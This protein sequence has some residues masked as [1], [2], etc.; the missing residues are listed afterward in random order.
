MVESAEASS[1]A[2]VESDVIGGTSLSSV[3]VSIENGESKKKKT[4]RHKRIFMM[5]SLYM[6]SPFNATTRTRTFRFGSEDIR[7]VEE[8]RAART[9]NNFSRDNYK[10]RNLHM[11]VWLAALLFGYIEAKAV[12]AVASIPSEKCVAGLPPRALEDIQ[13]MVILGMIQSW[14]AGLMVKQRYDSL[15]AKKGRIYYAILYISFIPLWSLFEHSVPAFRDIYFTAESR[16]LSDDDKPSVIAASLCVAALVL[17]CIIWHVHHAWANFRKRDAFTYCG[18]RFV[19]ALF[20]AS[21]VAMA[22]KGGTRHDT[23]DV[24]LPS[25]IFAWGVSLFCQFDHP[26]SNAFLVI[27]A[28]IFVQSLA[29]QPET[30]LFSP[31]S[32]CASADMLPMPLALRN[33]ST[34]MAQFVQHEQTVI[35]LSES[36]FSSV[37]ESAPPSAFRWCVSS[38]FCDSMR[39]RGGDDFWVIA[40][41]SIDPPDFQIFRW[42]NC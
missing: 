1:D 30:Q 35:N 39:S 18:S 13:T 23:F 36:N 26:I 34:D 24:H 21:I 16:R 28:S 31:V 32:A 17:I 15:F 41:T 22:Y 11:V 3:E 25:F 14:I 40:K 19:V 38:T 20:Y 5:S 33:A 8:T 12:C 9:N 42:G 27:C 4:P 29:V 10:R 2:C 37:I 7:Q 6:P